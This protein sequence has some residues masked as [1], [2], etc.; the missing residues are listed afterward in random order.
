M[1]QI[2]HQPV[3]SQPVSS[4][5][6]DRIFAA[7]SYISIL[8][9]VPLIVKS[10]NDKVYFHAKQ[11]MVL[12]GAEVVVWFILLM[13]ESFIV[14]LAP[15]SHFNLTGILGALAWIVFAALSLLGILF[16]ARGRQWEM[17]V[18]GKIAKSMRV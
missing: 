13:L 1:D 14:V 10:D 4:D 7:L 18:L 9:V 5:T 11:G 8:F 2:E 16:A 17:P 6:E 15:R 12:F 3:E